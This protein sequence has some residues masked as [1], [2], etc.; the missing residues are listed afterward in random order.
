MSNSKTVKMIKID[1]IIGKITENKRK[2][3]EK[4]YGAI[5]NEVV[6]PTNA[7]IREGRFLNQLIATRKRDRLVVN[8]DKTLLLNGFIKDDYNKMNIIIAYVENGACVNDEEIKATTEFADAVVLKGYT[9]VERIKVIERVKETNPRVTVVNGEDIKSG[10]M[11][12]ES[13]EDAKRILKMLSTDIKNLF[14]A[15]S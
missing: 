7:D 12:M 4:L 11:L 5:K 8:I 1:V 10:E 2:F 14:N 3:I 13:I 9:D 6:T 15:N